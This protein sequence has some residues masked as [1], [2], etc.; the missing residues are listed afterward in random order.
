[1]DQDIIDA[2]YNPEIRSGSRVPYVDWYVGRSALAR[3]KLEC[4]L[5]VAYGP[6]S[7]ETMDVFP[8][9]TA[10]SPV[11]LFIH[12]GYWRALSSKEFSFV[13]SGLVPLGITVAVMN[14]SLCPEV[15]IADITRQSRA[16]LGW[17]E[18]NARQ[19]SGDPANIYVAGHSAG[20]QQVGM[21]VSGA[22]TPEFAPS[23]GL[24]GG[25]TISGLFDL[26]P[27]Q[28]SWLQP[29]LKL[30]TALCRE[31]SPLFHI[32]RRAVPL[33]VSVGSEESTAFIGQSQNYVEAWKAGGLD[34]TYHAQPG[35]N[36]YTAVNAL[37]DPGS[38]FNRSILDLIRRCS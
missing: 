20:G 14:Y 34:A 35:A 33:L 27:L 23:A 9:A 3:E 16:A 5:D 1:M 17:L 31:Q 30:T 36:H 21:L 28:H 11:F 25:V 29:T 10:H 18:R 19:F 38:E 4:R 37:G 22:G 6:A 26:R 12:G 2:E 32:P 7:S 13:A 8:S 24:R 15:S